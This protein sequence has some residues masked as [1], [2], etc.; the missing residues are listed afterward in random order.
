MMMRK[1][2]PDKSGKTFCVALDFNQ[3]IVVELVRHI[4]PNNPLE[5]FT[6]SLIIFFNILH[7]RAYFLQVTKIFN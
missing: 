6:I 5:C 1:M 2:V 3:F 7:S 4:V